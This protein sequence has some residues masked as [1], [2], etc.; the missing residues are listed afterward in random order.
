MMKFDFKYHQNY[1]DRFILFFGFSILFWMVIQTFL[2]FQFSLTLKSIVCVN[3]SLLFIW[4]LFW[5]I[6]LRVLDK[7]LAPLEDLPEIDEI[8]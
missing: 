1:I 2:I 5:I 7:L 6:W 8:N 4:N 3:T